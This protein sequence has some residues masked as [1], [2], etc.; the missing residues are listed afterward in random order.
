[1]EGLIIWV[2]PPTSDLAKNFAL[3]VCYCTSWAWL[4][5]AMHSSIGFIRQSLT[6]LGIYQFSGSGGVSTSSKH[7]EA[8]KTVVTA[9]RKTCLYAQVRLKDYF[10]PSL[11]HEF[12]YTIRDLPSEY[13]K[14]AYLIVV[15]TS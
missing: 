14:S 9:S 6:V 8:K 11:K 7:T 15:C 2:K 5:P 10:P 12:V 1:M 4:C 3:S 13:D